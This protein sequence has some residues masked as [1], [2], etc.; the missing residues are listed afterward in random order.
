MFTF[1]PEATREYVRLV[2]DPPLVNR[3]AIDANVWSVIGT[4]RSGQ[5]G[6]TASICQ[7]C[8]A[9]TVVD[10]HEPVKVAE[11]I[12]WLERHHHCTPPSAPRP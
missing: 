11:L 3:I 1:P 8:G 7:T 6:A 4:H 10:R 12:L 5:V 9:F 2:N